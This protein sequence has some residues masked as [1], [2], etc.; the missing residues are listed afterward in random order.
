MYVEYKVYAMYM[1]TDARA[2]IK[3]CSQRDTVSSIR[4]E[5]SRWIRVASTAWGE[6]VGAKRK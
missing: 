4:L 6:M 2:L 3:I 1:D 5:N